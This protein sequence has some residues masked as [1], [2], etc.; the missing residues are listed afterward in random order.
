MERIALDDDAIERVESLVDDAAL[1]E[2]LT[3]LPAKQ[4]AAIEAHVIDER[5]YG[6][7][8]REL[9]CSESV[10][11]QRVSRGLS[12]MRSTVEEIHEP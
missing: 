12:A 2:A 5:E 11:R 8:A 3:S 6:D 7:V 1:T 4:R 10:V 9:G